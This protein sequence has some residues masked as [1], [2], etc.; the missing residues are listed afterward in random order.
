M[1]AYSSHKMSQVKT[2]VLKNEP[3][4]NSIFFFFFFLRQFPGSHEGVAPAPAAFVAHAFKIE[5]WWRLAV[6]LHAV[7]LHA[8]RRRRG[9]LSIWKLSLL[10]CRRGRGMWSVDTAVPCSYWMQLPCWIM[11]TPSVS[12]W[13]ETISTSPKVLPRTEEKGSGAA[14]ILILATSLGHSGH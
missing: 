5:T 8:L 9:G 4:I 3:I 10:S 7:R 14:L 2:K 6:R 13:E 1:K 12:A 11:Q